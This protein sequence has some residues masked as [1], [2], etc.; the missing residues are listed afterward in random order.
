MAIDKALE[1]AYKI[2]GAINKADR[3]QVD[4]DELLER[5][6]HE[7]DPDEYPMEEN[8]QLDK[9]DEAEARQMQAPAP[10]QSAAPLADTAS[11]DDEVS[12]QSEPTDSE[13]D[14]GLLN[15]IDTEGENHAE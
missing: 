9:A 7:M 8:V 13:I 6:L 5:L 2:A 4:A 3:G 1:E 12:T 10:K 15:N 14:A 11:G